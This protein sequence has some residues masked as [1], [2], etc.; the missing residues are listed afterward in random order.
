MSA[1]DDSTQDLVFSFLADPATHGLNEPVVRIDT[2]GAAVFLAGGDVYKVKRAVHFPFMDFSTLELRRRACEREIVLNKPNAPDL[3]L[4]V[5]PISREER[6][7]SLGSNGEIVEWAVHLKRFDENRT[8]DRF[9]GQG[10][11]D[12][13]LVT[14]LAEAVAASHQRAPAFRDKNATSSLAAQIDETAGS[15]IASGVFP[16]APAESLAQALRRA[17]AAAKPL[18]L[19]REAQG[20]VRRCHGDLHLGNIVMIGLRPTLFDALE[21]DESF[22]TCDILYDLAFLVMDFFARGLRLEANL[23]TNIYLSHS[24]EME[25]QLAGLAALPLFMSLR[26]AIR[27]KV[28]I[29]EP[30]RAPETIAAARRLFEAARAFLEPNPLRLVA[31]GGLSGS[32]KTALARKIA[33]S[34]GRPPGAVHLRSDVERK[35]LLGVVELASL[36]EDAYRPEQTAATYRRLFDLAEVA[37]AA[38]QSVILDA[39]HRTEEERAGA[40]SAC[41]MGVHFTGLWLDAPVAVRTRRVSR[42]RN[43]ASDA[44]PAVAAAQTGEA[45]REPGWRRLDASESVDQLARDA[46]SAIGGEESPISS[47]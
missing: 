2:H 8:L 30:S 12:A 15:L 17:F 37:L 35:R 28:A 29:L 41:H 25:A 42:R 7:L 6:G 16:A 47:S 27:A 39:T 40:A 33:P 43:D 9:A 1:S 24:P 38:G 19:R 36:A 20:Q 21:F 45:P 10:G 4:G 44:G 31:V 26:A 34:I 11:F 3:Y 14:R 32:G 46:L 23:L 22:A 5:V 13:G 18:L